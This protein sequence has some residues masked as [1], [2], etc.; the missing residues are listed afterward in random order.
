MAE[1][2]NGTNAFNGQNS[3][4]NQGGY[5]GGYSTVSGMDYNQ[6]NSYSSQGNQYS[7]QSGSPYQGQPQPQPVQLSGQY[8]SPYSH[9]EKSA[10]PGKESRPKVKKD[11]KNNSFSSK[12][13]RTAVIAAV[14]GLVAGG[15]FK[16]VDI[17]VDKLRS[18]ASKS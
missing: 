4:F 15:A 2:E 8:T 11:K 16:G 12:V 1:F 7:N 17:G 9:S 3:S 13:A 6:G 18:Y 5:N 10:S 14:F